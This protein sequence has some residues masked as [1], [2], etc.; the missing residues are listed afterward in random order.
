MPTSEHPPNQILVRCEN[1]EWNVSAVGPEALTEA[2]LQQPML[3]LAPTGAEV[4][5]LYVTD[6][7][8]HQLNRDYR[9]IDRPTD[10]LAFALN[11]E[12]EED[13]DMGM[14]KPPIPETILGDI[15][16]SL[17]TA[18]RQ[19]AGRAVTP[20]DE[21][22]LLLLHGLLHLLGRNHEEREDE[23]AMQAQ[24]SE[25]LKRLGFAAP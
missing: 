1:I 7:R 9:K 25:W 2:V 4:S 22:A 21:S 10:V 17:E 5:V 23:K 24:Q 14:A 18:S 6:K 20:V 8:I 12:S 16:I 15:V 3:E 13:I 11:D 19:A